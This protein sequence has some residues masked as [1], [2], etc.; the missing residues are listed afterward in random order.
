MNIIMNRS[1]FGSSNGI[2]VKKYEANEEYEVSEELGEVFLKMQVAS[3]K[4]NGNTKMTSVPSNKSVFTKEEKE[5]KENLEND[6]KKTT[7]KRWK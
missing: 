1:T 7:S 6:P 5:K 2:T 4:I 3:K